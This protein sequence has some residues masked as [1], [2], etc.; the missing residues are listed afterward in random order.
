MKKRKIKITSRMLRKTFLWLLL[1]A[2]LTLFTTVVVKS[3]DDGHIY[4][5]SSIPE[6]VTPLGEYKEYLESY[7]NAKT[8]TIDDIV[9]AGTNTKET[10]FGTDIIDGTEVL[11]TTASGTATWEVDVPIAG[12]YNIKVDYIPIID[13]GANIERKIYVNGIVPFDDLDNVSF[14]RV[15]GD[16]GEKSVDKN[17]NEIRPL[18]EE[19]P[20]RR[21]SYVK[22]QVGYVTEP[23][24]IYF[25]EGT[26]TITFESVREA[27]GIF[28][29]TISSKETYKTYDEVYSEYEAKGYKKVS[30]GI[31][32]YY[33]EGEQYIQGEDS[34]VR[35]S[36][37]IYA[38]TDRTSAYNMPADP[39]KTIL[40]SIGGTKWTTPGDWITWEF[41]V[42]ESGLYNIS[43]RAKQ[44]SSRGLFS[45]RK[46]YIDGEIPFAE[47][48]NA[49]FI[50]SSDWNIVTIGEEDKPYYFY[51]EAGTHEIT[52]EATLGDY[53]TQINRVQTTIN[54]LTA[55]YR[56]IISITGTSPDKYIDYKLTTKIP[57]LLE[58]F[59]E[60]IKTLEDVAD[61][62]TQISGEKSSESAS[63]DTMA[64]QLR[65]FIKKPRTI[66]RNLTNF[67]NNISSLG[68]WILTVSSQSLTVDYL[69]V[70]SDDYKL[71]KGDANFFESTWFGIK[72]FV[73]SFFFDYSN[74]GA[75]EENEDYTTVEVWFL[76]S[77]SAGREQANAIRTLVDT[78]FGKK[79]NIDLKVVAPETLLPATLAGKGPDVA[80]NL[81]NGTPINYAM[82]GAVQD[83][84]GFDGFEEVKSWFQASSMVPYEYNSGYYALPNTQTFLMMFYREDI[85][86]DQNW[87]V[88]DTWDDV[89]SLIP[90]LQLQNLQ[91]YLPLNTVGAS[92][93]VNQIFASK[94]YQIGGSFYRTDLNNQGKEYMES[95]FDSPEAMEAFEFWCDF[96]TS[97]GFSLT[98]TAG[99]FVNRFRTGEMPIGIAS[100]DMYNTLAVAAPE[101]RGKWKFA[102]IPGTEQADGTIDHSGAASGTAMVMMKQ[103]TVQDEAWEFM[104]WWVSEDTQVGYAREIEAILG[105]AAR[106]PTANIAA[107]KR[108]AWTEEEQEVLI[109]QWSVTVGVPEVPGGYYTGRN[110]ENAFRTV[111]NNNLNPRD[112]LNEYIVTI[113]GELN[114]KRKEFGLGVAD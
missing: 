80:I 23:Y 39:V 77:E 63:L 103:S 31:T 41:T 93:V 101:I 14:Q 47:A 9:I 69:I 55:I 29:I 59:E 19:K 88:P 64:I 11:V 107:F 114:R 16:G 78:T 87:D 54:E 52:L 8:P 38:I 61:T 85:F 83:I 18:Q 3:Y 36:S 62:I 84:S 50:Y 22:D 113:N 7:A 44:S 96:Y 15:W 109:K 2:L 81:P 51:L 72:S 49:K 21:V 27:M 111:V 70:H 94:L 26:N 46:V 5:N 98:I 56:Q 12:F 89:I 28:N 53:G 20:Q 76:T 68:T 91:F 40:N 75:T 90:D 108:L 30:G 65:N 6:S 86:N 48:Q 66:Q 104:K 10:T 102:V 34:T 106:H 99:T 73:Q 95:N 25:D 45:T 67:S 82:R 105:S 1:I 60:S 32:G 110:L 112:T 43:L 17:G 71:P 42:P 92:S 13:G 79:I 37:T 100:Y 74:I 33:K 24:L 58:T 35:S 97:Y 4:S 57:N